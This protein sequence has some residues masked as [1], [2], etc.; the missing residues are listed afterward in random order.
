[1]DI[2]PKNQDKIKN[3]KVRDTSNKKNKS[4]K[5]EVSEFLSQSSEEE[6]VRIREYAFH[7]KSSQNIPQVELAKDGGLHPKGDE[8]LFT[9]EMKGALATTNKPLKNLLM[10]QISGVSILKDNVALINASLAFL[11]GMKPKDEIET[12]LL[13]QM[14]STHNLA[15]VFMEKTTKPDQTVDHITGHIN[16]ANKLMKTFTAQMEAFHRYRGKGQQKVIVEHVTVNAGG[17]AIV[18]QIDQART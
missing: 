9:I 17:Q 18:G 13:V 14:L 7:L 16:R 2:Q 10:N 1:M 4:S 15:M 5:E 12:L 3:G 6:R 11:H 8:T